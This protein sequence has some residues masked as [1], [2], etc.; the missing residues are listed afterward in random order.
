MDYKEVV[1]LIA[2]ENVPDTIKKILGK[3]IE[4]LAILFYKVRGEL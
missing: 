1:N 3:M 2:R 4:E